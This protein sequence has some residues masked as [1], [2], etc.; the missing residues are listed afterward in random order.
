MRAGEAFVVDERTAQQKEARA[1][2]P[3]AKGPDLEPIT[4]KIDQR[5]CWMFSGPGANYHT[6]REQA[7]KLGFP[8]IV[9]Q[10]MMTTCFAAQVMLD[11]FG[12]GFVNGGKMSLKLTNVVWVDETLV[13]FGRESAREREGTKT[14]VHCDVWVEK[15]AGVRV[16]IGEASALEG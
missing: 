2:F 5:R 11:R 12:T 14:R 8:N 7:K 6:D 10:G 13:V 9:V 1:P 3:T 15:D 16:L 4:K